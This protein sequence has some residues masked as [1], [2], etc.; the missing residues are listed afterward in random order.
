[1]SQIEVNN[2]YFLEEVKR[3]QMEIDCA[4]LLIQ[5]SVETEQITVDAKYEETGEYSCQIKDETLKI[6]YRWKKRKKHF[7]DVSDS[8]TIIM[9][10]S[11][12]F[13]KAELELGAGKAEIELAA[14]VQKAFF[15][16]GAGNLAIC[17]CKVND[18][19]EINV[20]AGK[21]K[22]DQMTAAETNVECGVGSFSF[23]GTI[24]G[25]L[26]VECGVG[27]CEIL[28]D[29]EE[30]DYNYEVSGGIGKVTVNGSRYGGF[31]ASHSVKNEGAIGTIQISCGVGKVA[32]ATQKRIT[33]V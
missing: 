28:L 3:I 31:G 7:E 21:V 33:A 24:N 6:K 30:K 11:A 5:E 9:P 27:D 15:D 17:K 22:M 25:N 12:S 26:K 16:V 2:T 4:N 32:L 29:A 1:M 18:K 14:Q 10:A 20:G 23:N 19:L 13:E 8:I